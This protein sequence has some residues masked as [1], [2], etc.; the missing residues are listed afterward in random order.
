[1]MLVISAWLSSTWRRDAGRTLRVLAVIFAIASTASA[2]P[3]IDYHQHLL[4]PTE[5]S[6]RGF[7]ASD[8]VKMLDEA[9]IRRVIVLSMAYRYGNP[10]QPP[11]CR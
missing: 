7:V 1:V 10:N 6:P 11:L 8:L 2:Q 5:K 3:L 4:M 9:H